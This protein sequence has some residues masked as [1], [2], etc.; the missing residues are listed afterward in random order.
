MW[1]LDNLKLPRWACRLVSAFWW[2]RSKCRCEKEPGAWSASSDSPWGRCFVGSVG[3]WGLGTTFCPVL[4][5]C[6]QTQP[7]KI[8]QEM[9][10]L[11]AGASGYSL[12][13][14]CGL[15]DPLT[16]RKLQKGSS[17]VGFCQVLASIEERLHF[18]PSEDSPRGI[19]QPVSWCF[20]QKG[21]RPF[22]VFWMKTKPQ[23]STWKPPSSCAEPCDCPWV[24]AANCVNPN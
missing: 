19:L 7:V 17:P 16:Y 12:W 11:L 4:W 20:Q 23:N 8:H 18:A 15:P 10:Q 5:M 24:A 1:K 21:H 2:G 14:A 13:E 3:V 22:T 9:Q 6:L